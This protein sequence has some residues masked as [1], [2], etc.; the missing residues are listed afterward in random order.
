MR[1]GKLIFRFFLLAALAYFAYL[2]LL[3][4]LQYIPFRADAAFLKIKT[5][6][7]AL[8]YYLFF[9]KLHV[10]TS[11]FLLLSGVTQFSTYIRKKWRNL[12]RGMGWSYIS[13][14]LMAAAPS[15]IVMG[16]HANGGWTSQTS[17]VILGVLWF[18]F[19]ALALYFVL[20]KNLVQH[21]NF[22]I[23]SFALTLSAVTLRLWKWIIVALFH[24]PPMDVYRI[25][26]WLGWV[27]NLLIAE[28]IISKKKPDKQ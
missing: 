11:L 3:I 2:L 16:W 5:D 27:L 20:K 24:P 19:T 13:I 26:A 10:F 6:E 1:H 15:G 21:Q 4:T 22:M 25:V 8:P 23:R 9:F 12:H 14:I 17:F 18:L 7:V 28:Y